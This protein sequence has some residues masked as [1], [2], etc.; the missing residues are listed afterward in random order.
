LSSFHNLKKFFC[1]GSL[2]A[3]FQ[4]CLWIIHATYVLWENCKHA[5]L[6]TKLRAIKYF[7]SIPLSFFGVQIVSHGIFIVLPSIVHNILLFCCFP[8]LTKTSRSEANLG[9]MVDVIRS[10]HNA[11]I[12]RLTSYPLITLFVFST[13]EQHN[14]SLTHWVD[15]DST[16]YFTGKLHFPNCN[17]LQICYLS[18][19]SSLIKNFI[20]HCRVLLN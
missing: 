8:K 5:W 14:L 2:V 11:T 9:V 7:I 1:I 10:L 13:N 19:P 20:F 6:H 3:S 4:L 18:L 12:N 16:R 15:K 17:I